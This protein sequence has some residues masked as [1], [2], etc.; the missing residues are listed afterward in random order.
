MWNDATPPVTFGECDTPASEETTIEST[1]SL[2][3]G[4]MLSGSLR[5]IINLD[6]REFIRVTTQVK[7]FVHLHDVFL[8]LFFG[9]LLVPLAGL[10]YRSFWY[11]WGRKTYENSYPHLF[12]DHVGQVAKLA[13][14]VY[15]VDVLAVA[16]IAIGFD[17]G[18]VSQIP[19]GSARILFISWFAQRLSVLK[20]YLFH[21]AV[22][23]SPS[24]FSQWGLVDKLADV[25]L[26]ICTGFLLFD[27]LNVQMG[28]GL[29]SV[30][31]FGSVG[32]LVVGLAS[33][34]LADM[35]LNG[36]FLTTADRVR[37]GDA[38]RFGDGTSGVIVKIGWMQTTVRHYDN[39]VEV[40]PNSTLGMQRVCNLS[41][42][43]TCRLRVNLR[44][45]FSDGGKLQA[46]GQSILN[47][48]KASC[49]E[50]ITDGSRPFRAVW[51]DYKDYYLNLMI[52]THYKLP[53][54]G[55]KYWN[56]RQEVMKAI[57]RTV[58]QYEMEFAEPPAMLDKKASAKE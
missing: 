43:E 3:G 28:V 42:V 1:L 48:I 51:T 35:F 20:T 41:R 40:I 18:R 50:A 14:L 19:L 53:C 24:N 46:L 15:L 27:I 13:S 17:L 11:R 56:N 8:L 52:D 5:R 25:V 49:P 29:T 36:I 47:E 6:H 2:A 38:V 26:Y 45:R 34:D 33:K 12:F 16:L 39:L 22:E 30:F 4:Q 57:Y 9:W 10:F 32:T 37:E 55:E 54:M 23:K 21:R 44:F 58:E 7:S 31:A